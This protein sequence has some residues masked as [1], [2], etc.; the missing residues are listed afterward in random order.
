[1]LNIRAMVAEDGV[2]I[3]GPMRFC[4]L[5]FMLAG[6][7]DVPP[8]ADEGLPVC[9]DGVCTALE[10]AWTCP[11]D[12]ATPA[13]GPRCGDGIC[14]P[15]ETAATCPADCAAVPPP[16]PECTENQLGNTAP[17]DITGTTAGGPLLPDTAS[18]GDASDAPA[19]TYKWSAP[20]AGHYAIT[21][22]GGFAIVLSV[23]RGECNGDELTCSHAS[24]TVA[25]QSGESIAITITGAAGAS[26]AYE[27]KIDHLPDTCGDGLCG[28]SETNATC[29]ADCAPGPVCGD[30]VCQLGETTATCA[31]DCP[32]STCGDGF[33]ASNEDE[34]SCPQDCGSTT[35][36]P[37]CGD[38]IC[39]A[40]E[41]C[42]V[43]C[44]T[45]TTT[46]GPTCGDGV[47]DPGESCDAD[48]GTATS[49]CGDGSCDGGEDSESCPSDC[50][51]DTTRCDPSD[52][53][54]F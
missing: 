19:A 36:S 11:E 38:G 3:D 15:G 29:P 46:T 20:A 22:T 53:D 39:E 35:T 8:P 1:M 26:G 25:L 54:C 23:D 44:D 30:G 37:I 28:S 49:Y 14:E 5:L 10:S 50:G 9:G 43:D 31:I 27:L 4:A 33:C 17:V 47:C 48:C 41:S 21:A 52:P 13:G 45:T 16:P 42:A 12:C 32:A 51:D 40:G 34:N 6:C 2:P 24:S 18:C 7:F